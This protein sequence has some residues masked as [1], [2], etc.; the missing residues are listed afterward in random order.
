MFR[1]DRLTRVFLRLK[2]TALFIMSFCFL[3]LSFQVNA[4][5]GGA[6]YN[7]GSNTVHDYKTWRSLVWNNSTKTMGKGPSIITSQPISYWV[8]DWTSPQFMVDEIKGY[9]TGGL[10]LN[11]VPAITIYDIPYKDC[12]QA[13]KKT[14]KTKAEYKAWIDKI[15]LAIQQGI[16]LAKA[17][18]GRGQVPAQ[19]NPVLIFLEPDS[20]GL[21]P[22]ENYADISNAKACWVDGVP[23]F[24]VAD[25]Y[26]LLNYAVKKLASAGCNPVTNKD[27]SKSNPTECASF[28]SQVK[29]YLDGGN[30]GWQSGWVDTMADRLVKAGISSAQGVFTNSSNY[31]STT[32][33]ISYGV[34]LLAAVDAKVSWVW[35]STDTCPPPPKTQI[36]DVSRNGVDIRIDTYSKLADGSP[37][38]DN[39]WP[40]W[41]DNTRARMGQHPTL[42]SDS[43]VNALSTRGEIRHVDGLLWIKPMGETDGCWGGGP[44]SPNT[45]PSL[46][47]DDNGNS[48]VSSLGETAGW[49][50]P[51]V[52]CGLVTGKYLNPNYTTESMSFCD[53]SISVSAPK[54][55]KIVN[56]TRK[57][58]GWPEDTVTLEWEPTAGA[59]NYQIAARINGSTTNNLSVVKTKIY[60]NAQVSVQSGTVSSVN[61]FGASTRFVVNPAVKGSSVVY[62]VR[63]L[64]CSYGGGYSRVSSFAVTPESETKDWN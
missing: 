52:A 62:A 54:G 36:I 41:C 38:Q 11:Q 12:G 43:Y 46:V 8:G 32:K 53:T 42:F 13:S 26:E 60:E 58:L 5:L 47:K 40:Y 16:G 20:I 24:N 14:P 50:S 63:T 34:D 9:V 1:V 55:L 51:S 45:Q 10:M 35:C 44:V 15:A 39:G 6:L 23:M 61:G 30:S 22:T 4:E 18:N 17:T 21:L 3:F 57:S 25:R 29:V 28:R 37:Y 19:Y 27:G 7:K 64:S 49:G 59:C 2:L 56:E 48:L 33:E 31:H